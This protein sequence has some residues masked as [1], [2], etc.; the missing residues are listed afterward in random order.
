MHEAVMV[1]H[2]AIGDRQ[3]KSGALADFLG[4]KE[5]LENPSPQRLIHTKTGI[6]NADVQVGRGGGIAEQGA[7]FE[8]IRLRGLQRQL[9][10]GGHGV[11]RIDADVEQRLMNLRRV[12]HNQ[13]QVARQLQADVNRARKGLPAS[14]A[15]IP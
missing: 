9:T 2:G 14:C 1:A 12:G 7:D 13:G 3:S 6:D 15:S 8:R 10:S 5:R 4:R 11:A